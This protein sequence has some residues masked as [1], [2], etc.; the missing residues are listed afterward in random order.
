MTLTLDDCSLI[1]ASLE[2][3]RKSYRET[4]IVP[5]GPYPSYRFKQKH[6]ADVSI[7]M[8]RVRI[9]RDQLKGD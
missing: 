7:T 5:H 1:L 4:G 3:A 6:L 2:Y 9:L 8:N